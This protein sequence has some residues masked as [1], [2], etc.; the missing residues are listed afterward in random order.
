MFCFTH[1]QLSKFLIVKVLLL[2]LNDC[3]SFYV[4]GLL[5]CASASVID[6]CLTNCLKELHQ[7]YSFGVFGDKDELVRF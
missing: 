3:W 5:L 7:I 6:V 1:R 4:S 2:A